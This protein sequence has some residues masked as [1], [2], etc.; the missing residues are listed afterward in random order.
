MSKSFIK[1]LRRRRFVFIIFKAA[2][3]L[4]SAKQ[5]LSND[6]DVKIVIYPQDIIFG[7]LL[8]QFRRKLKPIFLETI[9]LIMLINNNSVLMLLPESTFFQPE[10]EVSLSPVPEKI[11]F[12]PTQ[13][14]QK[15]RRI[16]LQQSIQDITKANRRKHK[17]HRHFS[18]TNIDKELLRLVEELIKKNVG[19]RSHDKV[20]LA[21]FLYQV[22][23]L[24]YKRSSPDSNFTLI[25]EIDMEESIDSLDRIQADQLGQYNYLQIVTN[26]PDII[27]GVTLFIRQKEINRL[28]QI[29]TRREKCSVVLIGPSGIGK[30]SLVYGMAH[31]FIN[32]NK[33]G[34]NLFKITPLHRHLYFKK[35]VE[36]SQFDLIF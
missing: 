3:R 4:A 6:N 28:I 18:S 25:N 22:L 27:S 7:A 8:V 12:F 31:L 29:L 16:K 5:N 30:A 13:E 23:K 11:F 19:K 34:Q 35:I 20:I 36:I 1:S 26:D 15:Q 2:F 32:F 24:E 21:T 33:N 14:N 9:D 17:K 10:S